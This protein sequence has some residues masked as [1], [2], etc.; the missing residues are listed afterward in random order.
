MRGLITRHP[1]LPEWEV[2]V[3]VRCYQQ[4]GHLNMPYARQLHDRQGE[5]HYQ[6]ERRGLFDSLPAI[7]RGGHTSTLPRREDLIERAMTWARARGIVSDEAAGTP[8][9]DPLT[10]GVSGGD[11]SA[12]RGVTSLVVRTP[13]GSR[14][15]RGGMSTSTR[16]LK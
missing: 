16:G 13:E 5:W 9:R 12:G 11:A 15:L 1:T 8:G 3:W 7:L 6:H 10:P 4:L 14:P 2:K